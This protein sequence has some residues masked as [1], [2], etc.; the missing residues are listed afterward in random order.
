[1]SINSLG[2]NE[3]FRHCFQ[4]DME[5]FFHVVL[6]ASIRWLAH[7]RLEDLEHRLSQFFNESRVIG[8]KTRGGYMKLAN[9]VYG[10]FL[11]DF[12]WD[13]AHLAE[14]IGACLTLQKQALENRTKWTPESLFELWLCTDSKDLPNDDRHEHPL[15]SKVEEDLSAEDAAAKDKPSSRAGS[16]RSA[17][18]AKLDPVSNPSPRQRLRRSERIAK[19][20]LRE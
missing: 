12:K 1:M 14:W 16:K 5:S 9:V 2:G 15:A 19:R 7:N 18:V 3:K 4:D 10:I 17:G 6:Y 8:G 11:D 13:N 20:N